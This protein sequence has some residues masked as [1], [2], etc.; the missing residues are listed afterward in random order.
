MPRHPPNA[1]T[2]R[3]RVH[4]TNGNADA[5][6]P[7]VRRIV[8]NL[9]QIFF[10]S[11]RFDGKVK[12]ASTASILKPIHNVKEGANPP[13]QPKL[14]SFLHLW[15]I[16]WAEF[17]ARQRPALAVLETGGAYRDR[18]DDLKLAKLPLYQLS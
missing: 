2:L 11:A 18:T 14:N 13:Y 1:L 3:L 6:P 7:M 15:K 4:T 9:S 16:C 5:K 12:R 8:F 17:H 10:V